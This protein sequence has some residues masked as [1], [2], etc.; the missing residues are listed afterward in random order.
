LEPNFHLNPDA[1]RERQI[2]IEFLI[3]TIPTKEIKWKDLFAL[4]TFRAFR[5]PTG[6]KNTQKALIGLPRHL[7]EPGRIDQPMEFPYYQVPLPNLY[8]QYLLYLAQTKAVK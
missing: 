1:S 8:E 7:Y 3:F 5:N 6:L 4:E 2:L